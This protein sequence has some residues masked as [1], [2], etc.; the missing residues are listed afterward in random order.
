M[1]TNC[2]T[3]TSLNGGGGGGGGGSDADGPGASPVS[4]G[5]QNTAIDT[6]ITVYC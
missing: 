6:L 2:S 3:G 5:T 1:P 4:A